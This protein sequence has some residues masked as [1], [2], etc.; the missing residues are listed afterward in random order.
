M[1]NDSGVNRYLRVLKAVPR[2]LSENPQNVS[3]LQTRSDTRGRTRQLRNFQNHDFGS[4]WTAGPFWFCCSSTLGQE[5]V[6]N[7][8]PLVSSPVPWPT[9]TL[10]CPTALR[11]SPPRGPLPS[12]HLTQVSFLPAAG[13]APRASCVTRLHFFCRHVQDTARRLLPALSRRHGTD[14]AP[15]WLAVSKTVCCHGNFEPNLWMLTF[16]LPR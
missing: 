10:C 1:S 4:S 15:S 13:P 2:L 6:L 9:S 7:V 3:V 8:L 16:L 11:P 12:S 5:N 14:G